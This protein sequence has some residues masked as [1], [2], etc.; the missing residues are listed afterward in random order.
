MMIAA[1]R[2]DVV[3]LD[4]LMPGIDGVAVLNEVRAVDPRFRSSC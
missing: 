2:P 4:I 1:E 3:V